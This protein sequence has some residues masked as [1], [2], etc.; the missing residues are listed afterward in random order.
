M[1]ALLLLAA[2]PQP[3]LEQA[4]DAYAHKDADACGKLA[5]DALNGGGL[6]VEQTARAWTLRGAC[7]VLAGDADKAQ[8]SYA[9]ALRVN[10]DVPAA[11]NDA[12]RAAQKDV[13][14]HALQGHAAAVDDD[15]VAV[16]LIGD[17]LQLVRGAMLTRGDEELARFPLDAAHAK[18]KVSGV[19]TAG[20]TLRLL[21]KHGNAVASSDVSAAVEHVVTPA[22]V[23]S[24]P[25]GS[26]G[27][28]SG[29]AAAPTMLT[30]LGATAIGAGIV[31]IVASGIGVA[32]L[33]P[34]ALDDG[35]LWLVGVGASTGLF[36][37]GAALVVVDQGL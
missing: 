30:T 27:A 10:K 5:Q 8:R 36:L 1:L 22:P 13:A 14:P 7:F 4:S 29:A 34:K 17:D 23:A 32:S 24:R 12:F 16:E 20:I 26:A 18:H 28:P 9:V 11:D 15:T 19:G 25:S 33:G 31:G 21:D 6:D 3:L 2:T 35:Q 37:V